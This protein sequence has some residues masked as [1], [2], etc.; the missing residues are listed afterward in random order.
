MINIDKILNTAIEK[1]AS[2]VH[3]I[4]GIK[5]NLRIRR[6]LIPIEECDILTEEDMMEI[7]DYFVRGNLDKDTVFKETKK[8]DSSYEFGEI[9]FRV[10]ISLSDDIPVV[11][12]RLIK[13]VLPI[14]L[15]HTKILDQLNW[16][17]FGRVIN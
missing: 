7:Y 17:I 12:L 1:D 3:L 9:R 8:L 4:C 10:N 2:D 6:D 11:T 16:S 14:L 13:N 5:P 15:T